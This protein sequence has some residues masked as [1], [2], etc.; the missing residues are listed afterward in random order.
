MTN[1]WIAGVDNPLAKMRLFCFPFAGGSTLT[2]RAWPRQLSPEIELRPIKLPGREDR[3][4]EACF[5]A[6]APLVR[7]L[8]SF[9]LPYLD[10]PF[11][12][13]GHSMGALLA[14]ELTRELRRRGGPQPVCL[15]VSGRRAPRIPL[16]RELFHTL[17]DPALI[18]KL[19]TYFVYFPLGFAN[20]SSFTRRFTDTQSCLVGLRRSL[21]R[22]V[23]PRSWCSGSRN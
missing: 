4:G 22:L 18:H 16:A 23:A 19:L 13:F 7:T 10:L 15:M 8:A 2:Y 5:E 12:F 21:A 20:R 11:A 6:A 9:L 14:F 3:F 1:T 17:P